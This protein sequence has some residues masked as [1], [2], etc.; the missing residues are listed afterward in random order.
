[1]EVLAKLFSPLWL[2]IGRYPYACAAVCAAIAALSA[3]EHWGHLLAV[4]TCT[5]AMIVM[6]KDE[7]NHPVVRE[8]V[9]AVE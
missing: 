8:D 3:F 2:L 5:A 4:F 6:W 7:M 9:A 1:M